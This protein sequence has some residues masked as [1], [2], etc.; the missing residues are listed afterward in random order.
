MLNLQPLMIL[1]YAADPDYIFLPV[2][3]LPD[4]YIVIAFLYADENLTCGENTDD[5]NN[6]KIAALSFP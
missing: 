1:M 5:G 2:P 4:Q 6:K 3:F